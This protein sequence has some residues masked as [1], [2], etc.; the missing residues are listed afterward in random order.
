MKNDSSQHQE[1]KISLNKKKYNRFRGNNLAEEQIGYD[2]K[3]LMRTLNGEI[4][5]NIWLRICQ[6]QIYK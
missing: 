6:K 1:L 3:F 5:L 2:C 4:D